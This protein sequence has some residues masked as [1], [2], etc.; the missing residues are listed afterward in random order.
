[1]FKKFF[2]ILIVIGVLLS[3][4]ILYIKYRD[5][6]FYKSSDFKSLS[7][8]LGLHLNN[9]HNSYCN[10]PKDDSS[11]MNYLDHDDYFQ[12]N[13][14]FSTKNLV[15]KHGIGLINYTDTSIIIISYKNNRRSTTFMYPQ[16]MNFIDFLFSGKSIF[17]TSINKTSCCSH[18]PNNLIIFDNSRIVNPES[19][20]SSIISKYLKDFTNQAFNKNLF[21]IFPSNN[22]V[23]C[24]KI[25]W[26]N[27]SIN[28]K[29]FCNRD[30]IN[31]NISEIII[32]SLKNYLRTNNFENNKFDSI[33]FNYMFSNE[34]L[35]GNKK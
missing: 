32:D 2:L 5:F 22:N 28:I 3:V 33:Y 13:S 1:M 35:Q 11:F 15:F 29:R 26:Y 30:E 24:F 20:E 16:D 17:L 12:V 31:N 18:I 7:F 9:Y 10:Y 23:L 19:I 21:W 25:V 4:S 34:L 8:N 6:K 14:G 27:D